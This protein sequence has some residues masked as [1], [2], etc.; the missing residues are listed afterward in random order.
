MGFLR[1]AVSVTE[2]KSEDIVFVKAVALQCVDND[3][4]LQ[5]VF[6]VCEAEEDFLACGLISRDETQ[7]FESGKGSEDV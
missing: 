6:K 7:G 2:L 4:R 5:G 1:H 3:G